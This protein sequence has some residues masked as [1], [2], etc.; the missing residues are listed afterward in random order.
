[1]AH[2]S[3][4]PDKLSYLRRILSAYVFSRRSNLSF[5]HTALELNDTDD[6]A[7]LGRYYMRFVDKT[8]FAGPFDADGVPMLDYKGA[9]GI[10]YNPNAVAQYALG[11]HDLL[12]DT[13]D[14]R[15]REIFLRQAEWFLSDL[16]MV[17][18][19]VGLWEYKFDFEYHD[20]LK[21]PWR[22]ALAQGQGISVVVRAHQ[23]T[24][25]ERYLEC[26]S[27]A[28][29]AFRRTIDEPGGVTYVDPKGHVWFEELI[30]D[31]PTHVLNGFIWALFGVHDYFLATRD[32]EALRLFDEAVRTLERNLQRYDMGFWSTYHLYPTRPR[33]IAS[34][35]YQ[36][37]HVV[38]C[39]AMYRL[40]G[41]Q[42][43]RTYAERWGRQ[44]SKWYCRYPAVCR[45]SLFKLLH[46]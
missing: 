44:Y 22:S 25:D 2:C 15:Y 23:L 27:K 26:A 4:I 28:F 31:P 43:F 38:Q 3:S 30:F 24:N 20:G 32:D 11:H 10:Q 6:Y 17:D 8:R 35:Y 39:E 45:K 36:R 34:P 5:W 9:V 13:G 46:Y 21:A 16:R 42:V 1:M 37:L 41:K 14:P 7:S 33:M 12:G 18:E 29:N 19:D 40:T